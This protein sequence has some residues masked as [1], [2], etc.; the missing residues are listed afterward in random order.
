MIYQVKRGTIIIP[1]SDT[2]VVGTALEVLNGQLSTLVASVPA[3]E[4]TG[5][6]TIVGKD[7]LGG[8]VY[9]STAADESTVAS[10]HPFGT[11]TFFDG[12]LTLTATA[13]GTQSAVRNVVYNLYYGVKQG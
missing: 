6:A 9:A 7:S 8:S 13:N 5:T 11:P 4:G 1:T 10:V 12:T 2:V 3:L